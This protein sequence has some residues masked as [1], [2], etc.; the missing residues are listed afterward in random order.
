MYICS[1]GWHYNPTTREIEVIGGGEISARFIS[2]KPLGVA[3]LPREEW[4][5]REELT[6]RQGWR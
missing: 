4:I 6:K 2:P 1:E 5:S 3:P